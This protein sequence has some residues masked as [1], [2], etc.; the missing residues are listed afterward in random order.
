MPSAPQESYTGESIS[1]SPQ[2]AYPQSYPQRGLRVA[3]QS[4]NLATRVA[5]AE[6]GAAKTAPEASKDCLK[7]PFGGLSKGHFSGPAPAVSPPLPAAAR[8]VEAGAVSAVPGPAGPWQLPHLRAIYTPFI[9]EW[10]AAGLCNDAAC[11]CCGG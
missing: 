5:T 2:A 11:A 8:R 4:G 3:G 9:P 7:G 10:Q 1:T 6:A